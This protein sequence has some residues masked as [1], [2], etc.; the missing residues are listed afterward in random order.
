MSVNETATQNVRATPFPPAW[1]GGGALG[2]HVV[3]ESERCGQIWVSARGDYV[4]FLRCG[5]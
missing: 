5:V 4:I 2:G 1:G 3:G